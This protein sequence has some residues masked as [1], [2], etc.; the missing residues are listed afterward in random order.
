MEIKSAAYVISIVGN[1]LSPTRAGGLDIV[2]YR[3]WTIVKNRHRCPRMVRGAGTLDQV[4]R[5]TS[6]ELGEYYSL[7]EVFIS[8]SIC[9]NLFS[10]II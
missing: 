6:R 3:L 9:C 8:Y 7:L 10:W 1:S 4:S 5:S 2:D